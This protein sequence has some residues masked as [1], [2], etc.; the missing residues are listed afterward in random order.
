MM[1]S[2]NGIETVVDLTVSRGS[3]EPK[4]Y[5]GGPGCCIA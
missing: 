5:H 3:F 1:K 2:R 4:P